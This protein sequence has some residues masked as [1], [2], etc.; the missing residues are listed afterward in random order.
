MH[1]YMI[2][3]SFDNMFEQPKDGY[4]FITCEF[5]FENVSDS[6]Q[7]ISMYSFDCFADGASC[8]MVF[9]RDDVINAT[10]SAGRKAKGTV[11][12]EVPVGS[13]VVEVEYLTNAWTSN[14]VV[15]DASLK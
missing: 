7:I 11:T 5:E 14:R 1:L 2:F 13:S 8:E 3:D 9:Y 15:F 12:F 4:H 6:D 10:L